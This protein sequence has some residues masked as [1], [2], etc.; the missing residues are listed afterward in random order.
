MVRE[1]HGVALHDGETDARCKHPQPSAARWIVQGGFRVGPVHK[2]YLAA[3]SLNNH[4]SRMRS[5]LEPVMRLVH[6]A[7]A[8]VLTPG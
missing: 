3:A 1:V 7:T 8:A 5:P 6:A 4:T 2:L